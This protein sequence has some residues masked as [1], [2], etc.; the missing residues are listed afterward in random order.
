MEVFLLLNGYEIK[1]PVDEQEKL[2]LK[3]A[4]ARCPKKTLQSGSSE[5]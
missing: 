2:I 1:A 5:E 3:I 4:T